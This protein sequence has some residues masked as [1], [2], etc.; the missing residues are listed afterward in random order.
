M[1]DLAEYKRNYWAPSGI[2][3]LATSAEHIDVL[4]LCLMFITDMNT[5]LAIP[6]LARYWV[7][8]K[9]NNNEESFVSAVKSLAAFLAIRRSVTGATRGI[10]ANF[11]TIMQELCISSG[12][13]ILSSKNLNEEL[14]T[15]LRSSRI[16]VVDKESW[17]AQAKEVPLATHSRPLCRFL[18]LA[19]A[20]NARPDPT[21]Q[22]LL[23][24]QGVIPSD[25]LAFFNY[26]TWQSEKYETVEHIAPDSNQHEGWDSKIYARHDTRHTIGNLVLLPQKENSAVGNST[27]PRKKVF[28]SALTAHSEKERKDHIARAES[29]GFGFT[30]KTK[31]LLNN[32]GRLHL[33]DSLAHVERWTESVIQRRSQNV[34]ELAWD[35]IAPWLDG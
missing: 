15:Y 17:V 12:Q 28:Y 30:T 19:A 2:R 14:T 21:N 27:W 7:H 33:L 4:K 32:Q 10:D 24:R 31:D 1:A 6:V 20:D 29:Q 35:R 8:S 23:T 5:T 3:G 25:E 34:L 16:G 22:G 13:P 18:L 9:Q 11:R 26:K